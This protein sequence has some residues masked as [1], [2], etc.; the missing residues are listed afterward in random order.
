MATDRDAASEARP[1]AR[2]GSY[3]CRCTQ[4]PSFALS[5]RDGR[6]LLATSTGFPFAVETWDALNRLSRLV[7]VAEATLNV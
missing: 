4:G 6:A 2:C 3:V 1:C 5:V 7:A